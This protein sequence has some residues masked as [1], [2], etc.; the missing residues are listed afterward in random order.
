MAVFKNRAFVILSFTLT[1]ECGVSNDK[2]SYVTLHIISQILQ[3]W[4]ML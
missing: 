1:I 2:Q 3:V 4:Q